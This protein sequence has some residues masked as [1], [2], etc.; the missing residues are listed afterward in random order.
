MAAGVLS[1]GVQTVDAMLVKG[2]RLCAVEDVVKPGWIRETE[3][4]VAVWM[5]A[6]IRMLIFT[7]R[8]RAER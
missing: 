7:F 1:V 2:G 4:A 8:E 6:E 5:L 3:D